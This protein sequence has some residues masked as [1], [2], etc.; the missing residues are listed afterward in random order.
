MEQIRAVVFEKNE[1]P[2]YSNVLLFGK[3]DV[4]V[5][6]ARLITRKSQ[7]QQSFANKIIFFIIRVIKL[8]NGC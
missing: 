1:K 3:N 5:P 6:K 2:L 4:T 8:A 7:F